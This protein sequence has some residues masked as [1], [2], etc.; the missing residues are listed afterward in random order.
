[1]PNNTFQTS[2]VAI[3]IEKNYWNN[4]GG[5]NT[6]VTRYYNL[7]THRKSIAIA[8]R[9][10]EEAVFIKAMISLHGK[11]E[12]LKELG[13]DKLNDTFY[14]NISTG[15]VSSWPRYMISKKELGRLNK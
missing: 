2:C 7:N 6:Q 12:V 4:L 9:Y 15:W 11:E 10:H 5:N 14:D 8:D 13:V 1:M 3:V